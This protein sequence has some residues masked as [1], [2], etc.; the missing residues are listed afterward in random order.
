MYL[1]IH[2]FYRSFAH[3]RKTLRRDVLLV[4]IIWYIYKTSFI[5]ELL[6]L[7][8]AFKPTDNLADQGDLMSA[9]FTITSV[10]AYFNLVLCLYLLDTKTYEVSC[11]CAFHYFL[12]MKYCIE[13][14]LL[15]FT[16]GG[17]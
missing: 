17:K 1:Q 7:L 13:D 3:A 6:D 5:N 4:S 11:D 16:D 2:D 12:Y 10:F 14:V 8:E 9:R 15:L